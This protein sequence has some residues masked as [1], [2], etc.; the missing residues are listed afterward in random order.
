[1]H[2][3]RRLVSQ[4]IQLHVLQH[5]YVRTTFNEREALLQTDVTQ[6]QKISDSDLDLD[7]KV[8]IMP[9]EV[10]EIIVHNDWAAP[11]VALL[12]RSK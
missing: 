12:K 2:D 9:T 8:Q 4:E 11:I 10:N 7:A 6:V 1:M 5:P 3:C